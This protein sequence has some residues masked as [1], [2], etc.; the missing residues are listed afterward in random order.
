MTVS[1]FPDPSFF[2]QCFQMNHV[3]LPKVLQRKSR[4]SGGTSHL[5][6]PFPPT[7]GMCKCASPW[8]S[9]LYIWHVLGEDVPASQKT[10]SGAGL[11]PTYGLSD[12]NQNRGNTG[13][14][15]SIN[16]TPIAAISVCKK[17]LDS[18]RDPDSCYCY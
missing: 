12:Q 9:L 11:D 16:S 6:L 18:V 7:S 14:R 5:S 2:P 4:Q 1:Q 8:N 15:S 13:F 17:D 10:H 3:L